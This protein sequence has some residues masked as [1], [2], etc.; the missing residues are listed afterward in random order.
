MPGEKETL[1]ENSS[2]RLDAYTYKGSRSRQGGREMR[3]YIDKL[4]EHHEQ[5]MATQNLSRIDVAFETMPLIPIALPYVYG[6]ESRME[7][8]EAENASLREEIRVLKE[9]KD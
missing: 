8:L 3:T 2:K 6:L 5:F 4:R 9:R 1:L 7:E